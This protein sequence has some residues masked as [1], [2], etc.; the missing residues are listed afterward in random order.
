MK[1]LINK[2]KGRRERLERELER[3]LKRDGE[4]NGESRRNG[5]GDGKWNRERWRE[6][7][8]LHTETRGLQLHKP[9]L[10]HYKIKIANF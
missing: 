2:A 5:N 7:C 3:E 9:D 4:W 6:R 10:G 8:A 1:L